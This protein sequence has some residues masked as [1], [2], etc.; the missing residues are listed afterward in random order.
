MRGTEVSATLRFLFV[1]HSRA[2]AFPTCRLAGSVAQ[3]RFSTQSATGYWGVR[4]L[5]SSRRLGGALL[6]Q[7]IIGESNKALADGRPSAA[8]VLET[9]S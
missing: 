8:H 6:W 7:R 9:L 4:R 2:L 1:C 3:L 5:P